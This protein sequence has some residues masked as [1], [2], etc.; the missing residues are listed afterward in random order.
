MECIALIV[1]PSVAGHWLG[2][3]FGVDG[4]FVYVALLITPWGTLWGVYDILR[5]KLRRSLAKLSRQDQEE[6][7]QLDSDDGHPRPIWFEQ[8]FRQTGHKHAVS[9]LSRSLA[10]GADVSSAHANSNWTLLHNAS[11][12]GN[13]PLI[14]ALVKAGANLNARDHHA[15]R[16]KSS[17]F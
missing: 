4:R 9:W 3:R 13:L 2:P 10:A 8:F 1:L 6:T 16:R 14:E 5:R 11:E 17:L 7:R 15:G 12:L